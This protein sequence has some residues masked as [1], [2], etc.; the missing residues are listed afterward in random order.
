MLEVKIYYEDTDAGGVVY[1][2]N[3]LR[4]FERARTEFMFDRGM[5]VRKQADQGIHFVVARIE[6]DFQ[7]PAELGDILQIETK[8]HD[9]TKVSFMID[10]VVRRK[11]DGKLICRAKT[12]IAHINNDS[13]VSRIPEDIKE[14][15]LKE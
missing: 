11:S 4:Y 8:L 12:K 15:L 14:K 9:L 13:K 7:W 5:E 2:A 6:A 3:Y 1:Y 10:H